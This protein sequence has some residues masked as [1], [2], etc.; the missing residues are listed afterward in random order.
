[1]KK[2]LKKLTERFAIRV[3]RADCGSLLVLQLK[4]EVVASLLL[5]FVSLFIGTYY[6]VFYSVTSLCNLTDKLKM[7]A[8]WQLLLWLAMRYS[9][10]T[11]GVI[12]L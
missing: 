9:N 12:T 5:I 2:V 1:M 10:E 11:D 6:I 8:L 7:I 3:C 4:N